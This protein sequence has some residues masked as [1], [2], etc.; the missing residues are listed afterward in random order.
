M[1]TILQQIS[2]CVQGGKIEWFPCTAARTWYKGEFLYLTT[3]GRLTECGSSATVT[4]GMAADDNAA[5]SVGVSHPVYVPT[6][7]TMFEMNT[8]HSTPASATTTI[9]LVGQSF[10]YFAATATAYCDRSATTVPFFKVNKLS[11]KD[12]SGDLFGRVIV[13]LDL[14]FCYIRK[15]I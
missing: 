10:N 4:C 3:V 15:V 2:H 6:E 9:S 12:A 8:Y 5:D 14:P 7:M 13:S 11:E 1:A